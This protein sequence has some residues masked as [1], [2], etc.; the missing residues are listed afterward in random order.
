VTAAFNEEDRH[1]RTVL[2]PIRID[3]AVMETNEA[4]AAQLRRRLIGDFRHW[5]DHDGYKKSFERILR[6]LKRTAE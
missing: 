1:K 6:D 5:K 4:W 3:D 2:F